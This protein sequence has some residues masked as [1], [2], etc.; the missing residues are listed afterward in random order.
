MVEFP[1]NIENDKNR[2]NDVILQESLYVPRGKGCPALEEDEEYVDSKGHPC[3]PG[4]GL[5]GKH[6]LRNPLLVQCLAQTDMS[7]ADA[8]PYEVYVSI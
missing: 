7:K 6:V 4:I 1:P 5:E 3:N 8:S 2:H